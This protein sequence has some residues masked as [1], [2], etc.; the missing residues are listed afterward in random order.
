M[1]VGRHLREAVLPLTLREKVVVGCAGRVSGELAFGQSR[2]FFTPKFEKWCV[3]G[4][5]SIVF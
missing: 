1:I 3:R 5:V 4:V 2:P